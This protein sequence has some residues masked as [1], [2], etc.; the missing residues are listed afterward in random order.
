MTTRKIK[1][2]RTHKERKQTRKEQK[3]LKSFTDLLSSSTLN[4]S[5]EEIDSVLDPILK[6]RPQQRQ[7]L[8]N[9]FLSNYIE[10]IEITNEKEICQSLSITPSFSPTSLEPYFSYSIAEEIHNIL[11]DNTPPCNQIESLP[12]DSMQKDL[13]M[14]DLFLSQN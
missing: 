10:P 8:F 11:D 5:Q 12:A 1:K 9:Q 3:L 6:L 4:F 2:H 14:I 7:S 13:E